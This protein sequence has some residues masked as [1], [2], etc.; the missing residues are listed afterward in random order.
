MKASELKASILQLA[1][2]GKLVRQDPNDEPAG[3]LLNRI[4]K[5]REALLKAGK[6]KKGKPLGKISEDEIPFE[7]PASWEWV[8]LG[9]ILTIVMGQSPDGKDVGTNGDGVEFHQGKIYFTDKYIGK[10]DV[11][12]VAPTK[13]APV[14]SVLLCVRAPVGTVNL[15]EREIC[16]G[17][18]LCALVSGQHL[19]REYLFSGLIPFGK[20]FEKKAT[21]STFKAISL[22][23]VINQPFPLPPLA[24]QQRIVA[25]IEELMPLVEAYDREEQKLT[26]LEAKLPYALRQSILQYAVE[27]KL[28]LQKADEG[29]A[30]ELLANIRKERDALVKEGKIKKGKPLSPV[31][32]EEKPFEIPASWEWVRLGDI[33]EYIHRGKSPIYSCIKEIPVVAQKCIQWSGIQMDKAL[34]IDPDSFNKYTE[35]RYLR[36]NDLLWNSTGLGTLGRIGIYDERLTPYQI[37]VADSHV[38]VIRPIKSQIDSLYLYYWFAGP[39]VQNT[40]N[41]KSTGST[42]KLNLQLKQ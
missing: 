25:K 28:V 23:I 36:T 2:S 20:E 37:A 17:R 8:R 42:N 31:S 7:I 29:T 30:A 32:E 19:H 16:I 13:I 4:K 41:D 11:K 34:F 9:D 21:G 39:S 24:E 22:G 40:I 1:V 5:E 38:T 18:G 3:V 14:G 12:T 10:S 35:E 15:T 26:A 33:C 27:G 6:I